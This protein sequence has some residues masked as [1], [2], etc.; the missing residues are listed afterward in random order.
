MTSRNR[1]Q[2]IDQLAQAHQV[3]LYS[4]HGPAEIGAALADSA[5]RADDRVIIIGGDGTLQAAVS[6]LAKR[7]GNGSAP[8]LCMLGGGRTNFTA[9]D[10]GSHNRLLRSLEQL[11]TRPDAWSGVERRVLRLRT[12]EHGSLYGFFVAGALVDAVIRDCHDYR[13]RHKGWLR[14]GHAATQWRLVQLAFLRLI[15]RK[16]FC[17]PN[18]QMTAP[19]LGTL[20]GPCRILLVTSLKHESGLL[21]PYADRG[22]GPLRVTAIHARAEGFWRG[23]PALLTGRFRPRQAPT[24]GYLSG[25]TR[26]LEIAGLASICLDGQEFALDPARS[27]IIEPGP[28]FRFLQP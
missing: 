10:L 12:P 18:L 22:E 15:G 19:S 28:A 21:D 4:V 7:A 13:T 20:S 5:P 25:R 26:R 2:R 3:P 24:S 8:T 11:I 14:N 9:R 17:V 1:L 6:V 27:L 16:V 23:L